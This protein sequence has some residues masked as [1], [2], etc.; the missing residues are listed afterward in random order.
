MN[1]IIATYSAGFA[2]CAALIVAIGA[3][4]LFVLRQGLLRRHVLAVVG[5]CIAADASLIAVGVSGVAAFLKSMPQLTRILSLGGAMF[6]GWYG[7]LAF[8]RMAQGEAVS[9]DAGS[10]QSLGK[11]LS[12]L[13]GFTF[14]NPHVYLDTVLLMGAAGATH[15]A[16]LR[17]F[18]IAGAASASACWFALL[19][20]G[21][22]L[23][24]PL[25]ARPAAWRVLDAIVGMTM[26]AMAAMLVVTA[27]H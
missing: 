11:V 15:P 14:L 17:P 27:F 22:R 19:G 1:S 13:A 25:F 3:Q 9:V 2:L 10:A 4:N 12:T 5:F 23:L 8:R 20:Y 24:A 26:L 6:L 21:A 18:F 16:P 7:L